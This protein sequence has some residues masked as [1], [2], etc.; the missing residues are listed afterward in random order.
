MA[1]IKRRDRDAALTANLL[2]TLAKSLGTEAD[3]DSDDERGDENESDDC[4]HPSTHHLLDGEQGQLKRV[5][6]PSEHPLHACRAPPRPAAC[7]RCAANLRS[8]TQSV[9]APA[10]SSLSTTSRRGVGAGRAQRVPQQR[11]AA[12]RLEPG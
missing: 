10:L 6:R 8:T 4:G 11:C 5:T 9:P 2:L 1:G 12:P 3:L 7:L